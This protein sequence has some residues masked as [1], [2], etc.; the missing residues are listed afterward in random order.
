MSHRPGVRRGRIDHDSP[1]YACAMPPPY[2]LAELRARRAQIEEIARR[3][4]AFNVRVFGSVATGNVQPTSDV[5]LLV[6]VHLDH[7]LSEAFGLGVELEDL[8]GCHVDVIAMRPGDPYYDR[9]DV[10][11]VVEGI[12]RDAVS[13]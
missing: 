11:P 3:R 6:E 7:R 9:P 2:T 1:T 10:R 8:L 13:L 5:D 4:G 12:A